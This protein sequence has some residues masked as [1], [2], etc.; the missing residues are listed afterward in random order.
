MK[1]II[2]KIELYIY[3]SLWIFA[4]IYSL[5]KLI[6]NQRDIVEK[7]E[8]V[9]FSLSDLQQGWS[10]L[11]RYKDG[12]DIEWSSWKY[13]LQTS[14]PYLIFQFVISE[15]IREAYISVLKYWYILSSIIFVTI[16]MG[17]KQLLII[18]AQPVIYALILLFG[19]KKLSIWITSVILLLSYNSLK[20]KY[21][22]WSFLDHDDMYDEEVYLILFS[23]AWIEL[24]C[25]SY[26]L[27]YIDSKNA[28][29]LKFDDIVKMFS[30]ILYLPLLYMGPIILYDEFEKSFTTNREKLKTRIKRF[31]IDIVLFQLYTCVLDLSLHYIYFFA[32]QNNMELIRKL[33]TVAL[34]GAGLWMGLEF[35]M[36]Y[37]VS[38]GTTAAF[39]RLDN[40]VPP[41]TPRCI[42]RIH[43]Y[44]QMWRYFDVGLYRFLVKY[45]YKPGYGLLCK[46]NHLPKVIHKLLASLVTF[47]FIFVWHGIVW[48]ILIWS[49]INYLGITLEHIGKAISKQ[50]IY[51][52]FKTNILKT[53][54][55][56]VRFIALLC[57]PLLA[58]SA[59]S[60]FYLFAG[61]DVGNLFVESFTH[62]SFVN[63]FLLILALYCCCHV[64]I[65]L[66][67]VPTR[68][69]SLK[70]K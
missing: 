11:S 1:I 2:P 49:V 60:N 19:G 21:Y 63:S 20:Y 25:I 34:C 24:R 3:F 40:M 32:M 4:N 28:R 45:I 52:S 16:Y 44:S 22:F 10:L 62:P 30:Y 47:T 43:V 6:E 39:S 5:Y 66:E 65:A 57:S 42:A 27:D 36:K 23:V 67:D 64:S 15:V 68:N 7:E 56:E 48:H 46:C 69:S 59:I 31:A 14:W 8:K 35:H 26:S 55:M 53:K 61:S 54:A 70:N 38:Y 29:L 13:F 51:E 41:P 9:V 33:P 18:F 37:V 50:K 58:L 12:S 17:Y